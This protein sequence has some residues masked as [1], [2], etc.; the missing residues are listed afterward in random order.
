MTGYSGCLVRANNNM[1]WSNDFSGIID[2]S[3]PQ[4]TMVLSGEATAFFS[5]NP[6][7]DNSKCYI[8]SLTPS[9]YLQWTTAS[10]GSIAAISLSPILS[11]IAWENL[12]ATQKQQLTF[13]YSEVG[14]D[15]FKIGTSNL[16]LLSFQ[17]IGECVGAISNSSDKSIFTIVR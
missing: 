9:H 6:I 14:P 12:D 8:V 15:Q 10:N 16:A 13:N 2:D 5:I 7:L 4:T 1:Y 11:S 17:R 3:L